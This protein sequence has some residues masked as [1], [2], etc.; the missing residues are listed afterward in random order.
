MAQ[1]RPELTVD[2]ARSKN[3]APPVATSTAMRSP[4]GERAAGEAAAAVQPPPS[5][6]PPTA[7]PFPRERRR[8]RE[9]NG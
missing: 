3:R 1:N 4:S 6:Q 2:S 9:K 7:P 5:R 8:G